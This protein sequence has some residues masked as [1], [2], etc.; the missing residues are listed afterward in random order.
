MEGRY[1]VV[2]NEQRGLNLLDFGLF[3]LVDCGDFYFYFWRFDEIYKPHVLNQRR[4]RG[5]VCEI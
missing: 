5:V 3:Y 2:E 4:I 1:G